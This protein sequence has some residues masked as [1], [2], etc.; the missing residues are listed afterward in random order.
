MTE[1]KKTLNFYFHPFVL[2]LVVLFIMM[3]SK[4]ILE[5]WMTVNSFKGYSF[6]IFITLCI[7]F[8]AARVIRYVFR[9]FLGKP[10]LTLTDTTFSDYQTGITF[11]WK[12]IKEFRIGGLHA[13]FISIILKDNEKYI[14]EVKNPIK[15]IF[16]RLNTKLFGYAFSMTSTLVKGRDKLILENLNSHLLNADRVSNSL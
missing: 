6:T 13:T 3:I 16:Y 12:D 9:L 5:L 15:R 4:P 7:S 1:D 11:D 8:I 14:T 10:A 2:G